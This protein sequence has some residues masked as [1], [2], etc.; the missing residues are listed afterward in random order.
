MAIKRT[1][2]GGKAVTLNEAFEKIVARIKKRQATSAKDTR[3]ALEKTYI[4]YI[5][6]NI[7]E[8]KIIDQFIHEAEAILATGQLDPTEA[9]NVR[10]KIEGIKAAR[11]GNLPVAWTQLRNIKDEIQN[12]DPSFGEKYDIG[13]KNISAVSLNLRLIEDNWPNLSRKQKEVIRKARLL[14]QEIDKLRMD[15]PKY[16]DF[17]GKFYGKNITNADAAEFIDYLEDGLFLDTNI[18]IESIVSF[19]DAQARVEV[20]FEDTNFNRNFKGALS[21]KV[22]TMVSAY[23]NGQTSALLKE[24]EKR[25]EKFANIRSSPGYLDDVEELLTNAIIGKKSGGVRRSK[26]TSIKVSTSKPI[27]GKKAAEYNKQRKALPQISPLKKYEELYSKDI[28]LFGIQSL[29][30]Q[31]LALKVKEE[32]GDA[33]DPPT[34]LRYQ[35]GRFSDS[36]KL[37][38]LTRSQS[39][40]L[41]GSYTYQRYPYDVFLPGGK[42][43]TQIRDPRIYIEGAIRKLALQIL[44]RKF[45]GILL[46]LQ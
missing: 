8:L 20:E 5:D 34:K 23:L 13:H 18:E 3:R 26:K 15:D 36:A 30:N 44:S 7:E 2:T 31:A 42:L 21:S 40:L 27:I 1:F 24:I 43:H 41:V 28:N 32:M 46:E 37:L 19:N 11:E 29:I 25:P 10:P 33:N 4:H 16:K 6:L 39:G 17:I 45:P 9:A 14:T 12:I 38:T 22:G 35:T